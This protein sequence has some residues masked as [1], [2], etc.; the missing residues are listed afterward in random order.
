MKNK[1]TLLF[2]L[3]ISIS[4]TKE[5]E[6]EIPPEKPKMVLYSTM[7]PFTLPRPKPLSLSIKSTKHIY[8]SSIAFIQNADVYLYKDDQILDT[9]LY[10]DSLKTYPISIFPTT[11]DVFSIIVQK[12]GFETVSAK[13]DIPSKVL[14]TDTLIMPIAYYDETGSV[15]SQVSISFIDPLNEINYYEIALSD[16][17]FSYDEPENFYELSSNNNIITSESYYPSLINFDM[18]KPKHLLFNDETI[19]GK[20]CNLNVFYTPPQTESD[21]RYI[22]NHYITI[23]LRSVTKDYYKYKTT[24]I[25]QLNNREEDILYGMGEPLNVISNVKNGYGLFSGFNNDMVTM[26]I[27]KQIIGE[28]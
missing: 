17:A 19:N 22:S 25:Q 5:I 12:E 15:F 2:I 20:S 13:C 23:H 11:G 18:K 4:C 8:D 16:I 24:M 26:H 14:I 1:L 27:N 28:K 6:I 3:V 9:L 21:H 10:V 7:V